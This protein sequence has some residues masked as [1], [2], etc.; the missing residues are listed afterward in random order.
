MTSGRIFG[1]DANERMSDMDFQRMIASIKMQL[2]DI[3]KY[4]EKGHENVVMKLSSV[5]PELAKRLASLQISCRKLCNVGNPHFDEAEIN[6]D[7][8]RTLDNGS[9]I[10]LSESGEILAGMGGKYTGQNIGDIGKEKGNKNISYDTMP[11]DVKD[12]IDK[13]IDPSKRNT[14]SANKINIFGSTVKVL[15]PF[16]SGE[17]RIEETIPGNARM[18]RP[19]EKKTSRTTSKEEAQEIVA[20]ALVRLTERAANSTNNMIRSKAAAELNRMRGINVSPESGQ[21]RRIIRRNK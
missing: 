17:Y 12:R 13:V 6:P 11:S 20:A 7:G 21:Q 16:D 10:N 18:K 9:R 8:W 2:N 15:T 4:D 14:V 5:N 19:E 3:L 1:I